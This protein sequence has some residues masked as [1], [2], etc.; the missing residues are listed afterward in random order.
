MAPPTAIMESCRGVRLRCSP[1]SRSRMAEASATF[2]SAGVPVCPMARHRRSPFP[3]RQRDARAGQPS[4]AR[5]PAPKYSK[6]QAVCV[7]ANLYLDTFL[8]TPL[9]FTITTR[10]NPKDSR[11][12]VIHEGAPGIGHHLRSDVFPLHLRLIAIFRST[13]RSHISNWAFHSYRDTR[14][15]APPSA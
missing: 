7:P 14:S 3:S 13:A 15:D 5:K 12:G 10:Q 6:G 8:R 9:F 1:A 11:R 4:P 2:V